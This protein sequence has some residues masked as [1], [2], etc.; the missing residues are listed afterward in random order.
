[1]E[2]IEKI[3]KSHNTKIIKGHQQRLPCN[4]REACRLDGECRTKN[5]VYKAEVSIPQEELSMNYI[6]ISE[7]ETKARL[8]NHYKAFNDRKYIKDSALTEYIWELKDRGITDYTI[9]WS[10]IRK[11]PKFNKSRGLCNLCIAE[12]LE[13]SNFKDRD[14]LINIR[15]QIATHCLHWRKHTLGKFQPK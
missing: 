13:I 14:R 2:N 5:A 15:L 9:K 3:I 7:P 6:G 12:K 8:S 4:C 11:V 1:M 10:I